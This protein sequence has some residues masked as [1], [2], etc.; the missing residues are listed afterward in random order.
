MAPKD[1]ADNFQSFLGKLQSV[2]KSTAS[3]SSNPKGQSPTPPSSSSTSS[4]AP[5]DFEN[6]YEA[7]S[8]LW[9]TKPLTEQEM[10]A[11]MVSSAWAAQTTAHRAPNASNPTDRRSYQHH[12]GSVST[13]PIHPYLCKKLVRYRY[14]FMF[15]EHEAAM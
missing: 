5:V 4:S 10:E 11:I 1:V 13:A 7:P 2:S 8:Y 9:K 14:A 12:F 3:P 15:R 6:F